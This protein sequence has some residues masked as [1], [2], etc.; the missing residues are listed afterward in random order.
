MK[1]QNLSKDMQVMVTQIP[2]GP[3]TWMNWKY[4]A[5]VS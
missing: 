5:E 4:L 3:Q 1:V 2:V